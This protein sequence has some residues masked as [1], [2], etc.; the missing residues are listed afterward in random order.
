MRCHQQPSIDCDHV[1]N[2]QAIVKRYGI[3]AFFDPNRCQGLCHA[4]HS[5]KT[6]NEVGFAGSH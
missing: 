1:E 3:L 4:C 2:A 5:S 6:A